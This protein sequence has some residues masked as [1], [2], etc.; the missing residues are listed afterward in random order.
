MRAGGR[1][2]V[3]G[4]LL[5]PVGRVPAPRPERLRPRRVADRGSRT[6]HRIPGR[7]RPHRGG[8]RH[9]RCASGRVPSHG[10]GRPAASS[11]AR[12]R[13]GRHREPGRSSRAPVLDADL[14]VY[15][16][17]TTA[18]TTIVVRRP[19]A[20]TWSVEAADPGVVLTAVVTARARP[21]PDVRATTAPAGERRRLSWTFTAVPGRRVQLVERGDDLVRTITTTS[22][23]SGS[24]VFRSAPAL[25][26]ARTVD[27]V[28]TDNGMPVETR[29]VARY[30]ATPPAAPPRPSSVAATARRGSLAI[31]FART[32]R[33]AFWR[34]SLRGSGR[35]CRSRCH[36]P[37]VTFRRLG[38]TPTTVVVTADRSLRPP[39]Q[40]S[41]ATV[42]Q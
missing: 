20:G 31:R 13:R 37:R 14:F 27:A 15:P 36:A 7:R 5:G 39:L 38:W 22:R 12:A 35:R 30:R 34:L 17:T 42:R 33:A 2:L 29:V 28:V 26:T 18:T 10:G 4:R 41:T 1:R 16:D 23:A 32:P 25:A 9:R 11:P 3:Q 40:P 21:R 8:N 24:V 19:A 6:R